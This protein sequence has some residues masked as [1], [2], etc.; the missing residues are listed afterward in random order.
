MEQCDIL[1][2]NGMV[3]TMDAEN[4]VIDSGWVAVEGDRIARVGGSDQAAPGAAEVIDARGGL[5]L[6][7]L[8]NGHTHAA[9]T[10]FRGLADDLPL[11]DWLNHY[12]F[13]VE[14]RMDADFV[15]QG[16]PAGLRRDD[17]V[18]HHHLLRHV[19]VRGRGGP[20]RPTAGMRC[21]VGEVLYDFP[22]PNYGPSKEGLALHRMADPEM[23][24][25]PAGLASPWNPTP[26]SP[27]ALTCS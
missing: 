5:V 12:I 14:S 16:H 11:M 15:V 4:R 3:L 23:A 6:P 8:I 20:G 22:S 10:P 26:S 2:R 17:P 19:P 1:I 13:P 21:L 18:G 27:A 24:G 9:M 25:R 7:G